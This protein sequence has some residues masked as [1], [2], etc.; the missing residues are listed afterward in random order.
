[1][2]ESDEFEKVV[3]MKSVSWIPLAAALAIAPLGSSF[4]LA[5]AET[6]PPVP[7]AALDATL[8]PPVRGV[9]KMV[10]SGVAEDVIQIYIQEATVP[11]SLTPDAIIQ[12]RDMG[13]SSTLTTAMLAHDK[14]LRD[15]Y[16]VAGGA[17]AP[18]VVA[19]PPV[20]PAVAPSANDYAVYNNLAP[21]GYWSD[22]PDYGWCWQPYSWV[23]YYPTFWLGFG[24]WWNCPGHGWCWSPHSHFHGYH[25]GFHSGHGTVAFNHTGVNGAAGFHTASHATTGFSHA[26]VNSG[27]S[28]WVTRFNG[29]SHGS[30]PA[31]MH[32]TPAVMHSSLARSFSGGG[33]TFRAGGGA[34][35]HGGGG[36]AFH[37]GGGFRGGFSGGGSR[38][39]FSGGGGHR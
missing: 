7:P 11:F 6:P 1:V 35:F 21:Y 39:G 34:A 4:A 19:Q 25:G 22:L 32:S 33:T 16:G 8:S 14:T 3:I 26:T 30:T 17:T 13:F 36:A 31:M 12:L 29:G 20:Q 2:A 18:Q 27:S 23:T 28:P 10:K 37:G 5:T 38:G 24:Y 15:S 9:I